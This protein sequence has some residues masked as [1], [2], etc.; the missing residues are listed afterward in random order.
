MVFQYHKCF[1]HSA[2]LSA[3]FHTPPL[4]LALRG[5]SPARGAAGFTPAGE[6]ASC[7]DKN[8][9]LPLKIKKLPFR[10]HNNFIFHIKKAT[11]DFPSHRRT[12]QG[13]LS[14]FLLSNIILA[15]SLSTDSMLHTDFIFTP[16]ICFY[17]VCLSKKPT[18]DFLY[19]SSIFQP[20]L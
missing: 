11:L 18:T 4:C 10:E 3:P 2:A 19:S 9:S 1:L 5:Y 15:T 14:E 8:C 12:H 7:T 20:F 6:G 16:F 17:S 13:L